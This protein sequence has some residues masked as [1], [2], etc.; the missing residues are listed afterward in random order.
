LSANKVHAIV[1]LLIA[2]H[3]AAR[4][5]LEDGDIRSLRDAV[6]AVERD[7]ELAKYLPKR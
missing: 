6:V 1:K 7:P 4:G 3:V 5:F 2:V